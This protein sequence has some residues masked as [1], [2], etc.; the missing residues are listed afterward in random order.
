MI[1]MEKPQ[2]NE[3]CFFY[4]DTSIPK[5]DQVI[6]CMCLSCH[7]KNPNLGWF[8]NGSQM[9]YGEHD[10]ICNKCGHQISKPQRKEKS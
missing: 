4:V 1:S 5:E 9:G 8:W 6:N 10:Y 7:E 3:D 2:E